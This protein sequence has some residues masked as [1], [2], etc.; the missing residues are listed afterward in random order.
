MSGI[1]VRPN[2]PE[3]RSAR[4]APAGNDRGPSPA[5]VGSALALLASILV[6][7]AGLIPALGLISRDA[8]RQASG[9]GPADL[10]TL[11]TAVAGPVALAI[12]A[13]LLV[14]IIVSSADALLQPIY[15][16][17]H[18]RLARSADWDQAPAWFEPAARPL[19]SSSRYARAVA[20]ALLRHAI[21]ALLG[22]TLLGS[23][24]MAAE[25]GGAG[26][27]GPAR[28]ACSTSSSAVMARGTDAQSLPGWIPAAPF[29]PSAHAG[30][31]PAADPDIG[32]VTSTGRHRRLDDDALLVVRRG[33]TLWSIAARSL[34]PGA[35]EAQI[36]G[37]WPRWFKANR[38][39]I[40]NDPDH[41]IPG[42]RLRPPATA[43]NGD[44][45]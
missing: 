5:R 15:C 25:S 11:V 30:P 20:P 1:R 28:S 37:E 31:E 26:S 18:A 17:S 8:W 22:V 7:L 44:R 34:G 10:G 41:L 6:T 24:A 4:G 23:P 14:A 39:V 29:Q 9:P 3:L 42:E 45:S 36:A 38:A 27:L 33:D 19:A 32:A 16:R 43:A 35:T 21:A 40:G 12:A 13:W 2:P